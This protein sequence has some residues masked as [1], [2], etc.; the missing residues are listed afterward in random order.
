M[1]AETIAEYRRG[2]A[3]RKQK[4]IDS[5]YILTRLEGLMGAR[6]YLRHDSEPCFYRLCGD[7]AFGVYIDVSP[8][9]VFPT[10]FILPL[11]MPNA[12][13]HL[14]YG[15][16]MHLLPGENELMGLPV[17]AQEQE[18]A[19][20]LM[21]FE[22][23]LD[24]CAEPYLESVNTV[25]KLM[26]F[27]E[28]NADPA[29][30]WEKILS[31]NQIRNLRAY[32]SGLPL[33]IERLQLYGWLYLGQYDKVVRNVPRYIKM[34]GRDKSLRV[35]TRGEEAEIKAQWIAEAEFL[36][37]LTKEGPQKVSEFLAGNIAGSIENLGLC[38]AKES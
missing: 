19:A 27:V 7:L 28:R 6:G 33:S 16:R 3:R 38:K 5:A 31:V 24:G 23:V 26:R 11:F 25:E 9:H 13:L 14:E 12:N 34:I 22:R 30:L 37:A 35:I 32:M 17:L 4:M 1:D 8:V 29:G 36:R 18:I 21:E 20:W 10:L 2:D 15:R